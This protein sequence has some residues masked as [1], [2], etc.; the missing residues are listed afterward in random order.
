MQA[1]IIEAP[2]LTKGAILTIE[3]LG[4]SSLYSDDDC[5]IPQKEI[6]EEGVSLLLL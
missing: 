4:I 1:G 6:G 5:M 2:D 3:N